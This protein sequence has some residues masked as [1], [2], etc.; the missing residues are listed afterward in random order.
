MSGKPRVGAIVA[1]VAVA[2]LAYQCGHNS[3]KQDDSGPESTTQAAAPTTPPT[4]E[5]ESHSVIPGNGTHNIGGMDGKDWGVYAATVPAGSTCQWSIR[6]VAP[7]RPGEIL[8]EGQGA[9][10]DVVR[11]SIQPDGD[12]S[13][14]T[15]EIDNDHRIVFMTNGCGAWSAE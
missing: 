2:F 12:V 11:A 5:A 8:D 9:A 1:V 7:Y 6:S 13:T 4:V 15:G 3:E 14:F 10:G